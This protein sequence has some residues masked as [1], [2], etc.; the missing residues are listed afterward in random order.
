MPPEYCE[1]GPKKRDL[2][3]CER[4]LFKN[5]PKLFSEIYPGREV[6]FEDS[7]SEDEDE[8]SKDDGKYDES[9]IFI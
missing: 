7:K 8:E 9:K 1:F 2:D 5:H 4:W 3:N 6:E